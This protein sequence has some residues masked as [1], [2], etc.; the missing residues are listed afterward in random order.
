MNKKCIAQSILSLF[1][2]FFVVGCAK[3]V[4]PMKIPSFQA[5]E[6]S[7]TVYEPKV[8]NFLI[9]MDTSRSMKDSYRGIPK[10]DIA[11]LL[12]SRLNM[13]IPEMDQI[14]AFR[15]FGHHDP[16]APKTTE[17]FL[18][19]KD[20]SR[21][22]MDR[23]IARV[24]EPYKDSPTATAMVSTLQKMAKIPGQK[25]IV[26]V[27]DGLGIDDTIKAI[28]KLQKKYGNHLCVYPVQIGDS[29][30]G[31]KT[32][33]R[34]A[35]M[36]GCG[37]V[38]RAE[39]ILGSQGMAVFVETV[40][41]KTKDVAE[42]DTDGDGIVNSMDEC[43]ETPKGAMVNPLGCWIINSILFDFD[44]SIIKP[45]AFPL[46]NTLSI[47]MKENP[48]MRVKV[49]GHT[50][51]RGSYEYNVG[52]SLRRANAVAAYL[53]KRGITKKQLE[54]SGFSFKKPI[55]KNTTGYGRSRNRR[56]EII[57]ITNKVM[58]SAPMQSKPIQ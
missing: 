52:L 13:T 35:E 2:L 19:M 16:N 18:G 20:Y 28:K 1:I 27:S 21:K 34:L 23:S 3:T 6:F 26:L 47:I 41:L 7:P 9:V 25:A 40:F 10:F 11:K 8:N 39:D 46:L 4:P 12:V 38:T 55:A 58:E 37:F 24:Q 51:N 53:M 49:H 14:A 45:E 50:D 17:L 54:I 43:P 15:T 56:V 5:K 48:K 57:P 29:S 44:K 36:N 22:K 42:L 31:M 30:R 33:T 32:M